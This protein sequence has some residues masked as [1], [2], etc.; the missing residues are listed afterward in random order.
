VAERFGPVV[1][2]EQEG[3]LVLEDVQRRI[4]QQAAGLPDGGDDPSEVVVFLSG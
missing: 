1:V 2:A 4:G 3:L